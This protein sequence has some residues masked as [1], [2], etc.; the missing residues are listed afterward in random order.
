MNTLY[1]WAPWLTQGYG[2]TIMHWLSSVYNQLAQ[3]TCEGTLPGTVVILRDQAEVQRSAEYNL[4]LIRTHWCA[5]MIDDSV[6]NELMMWLVG[7][8][9]WTEANIGQN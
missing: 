9:A 5:D 4:Y 6:M 7:G 2:P 3:G 1:T 8:S